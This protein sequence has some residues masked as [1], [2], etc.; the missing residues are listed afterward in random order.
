M[1]WYE[2][3]KLPGSEQIQ[4][5]KKAVLD[6]GNSSFF[7]RVPAPEIIAGNAGM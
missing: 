4:F 5:V 3:I 6:R 7:S 2:A 1:P